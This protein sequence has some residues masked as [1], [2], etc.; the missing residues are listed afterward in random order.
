MEIGKV[1]LPKKKFIILSQ[2]KDFFMEMD[3]LTIFS[4]SLDQL[5]QYLKLLKNYPFQN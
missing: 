2:F 3:Y 4:H 5:K 1:L